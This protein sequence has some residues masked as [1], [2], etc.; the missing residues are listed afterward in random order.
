[1]ATLSILGLYKYDSSIFDLLQLPASLDRQ[2]LIDNLLMECGVMET[3]I[4]DPDIMKRAIGYWSAKCI[5]VWEALQKTKE[6]NYNPIWNK[7]GVFTEKETRDLR[8]TGR[9]GTVN[10]VSAYDQSGFTNQAKGDVDAA[11]T[12]AGTITR[13]RTE[14]G[15]IGLTSTQSLIQEQR[16]VE[17][18]NVYDVIIQDFKHR[19]CVMVY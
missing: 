16:E 8:G 3:Y 6:Y 10:A 7:D 17:N 11:T 13:E 2:T 5:G 15:N 9:T 4:P 12:D 18:F 14:K 1:M 19:F